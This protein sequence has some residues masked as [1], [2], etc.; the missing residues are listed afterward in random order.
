MAVDGS[1]VIFY[2]QDTK[3]PIA[4]Q[5]VDTRGCEVGKELEFLNIKYISYKGKTIKDKECPN[6][7]RYELET[8]SNIEFNLKKYPSKRKNT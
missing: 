4:L 7:F 8:P 5:L 1:A 2:N 3:D 6:T